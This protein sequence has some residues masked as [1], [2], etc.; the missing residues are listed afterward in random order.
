MVG[1]VSGVLSGTGCWEV[2]TY[3]G[4]AVGGHVCS[5]GFLEDGCNHVVEVVVGVR[6]IEAFGESIDK[7][8]WIWRVNFDLWIGSILVIY[9]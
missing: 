8:S 4:F 3:A 9:G 6:V 5:A 1:S 7:N 2:G